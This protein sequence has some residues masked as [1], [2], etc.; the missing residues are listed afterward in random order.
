MEY[1]KRMCK[2][3]FGGHLVRCNAMA[4]LTA[5]LLVNAVLGQGGGG[6]FS[7]LCLGLQEFLPVYFFV[8]LVDGVIQRCL[9][10]GKSIWKERGRMLRLRKS[11]TTLQTTSGT[12]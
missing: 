9:L 12:S 8:V 5:C 6:L 7:G 2:G 10:S 11:L 3:G 1:I 4:I